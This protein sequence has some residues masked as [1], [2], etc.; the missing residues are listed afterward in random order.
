MMNKNK[1]L[2]IAS[3]LMVICGL[4]L[5]ALG[6]FR[7]RESSGWGFGITGLS[8]LCSAWVFNALKGRL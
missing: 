1:V 7:Y 4:S 2:A 8:F 5:I 3:V 6:V